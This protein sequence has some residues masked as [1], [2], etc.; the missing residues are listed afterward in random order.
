MPKVSPAYLAQRRAQL[1]DTALVF[2]AQHGFAAP[3][4]QLAQTSGHSIG[5][6]YHVFPSKDALIAAVITHVSA[7]LNERLITAITPTSTYAG[8][9]EAGLGAMNQFTL[10]A[11]P[12]ARLLPH[13]WAE[14]LSR[15][16]I[17]QLIQQ[18]NQPLVDVLWL[19]ITE[20][21]HHGILDDHLEPTGFIPLTLAT[22]QGFLLQQLLPAEA[23][24]AQSHR[25]VARWLFDRP[26]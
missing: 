22:F 23:G 7:Q 2:F 17:A 26:A 15:P 13:L 21:Q 3:M 1:L 12:A 6:W 11:L 5:C 9:I 8:L 20:F 18:T 24:Y 14:A 16:E 4:S 10:D 19:Q 25:V